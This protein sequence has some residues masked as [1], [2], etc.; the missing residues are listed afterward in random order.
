MFKRRG[1][2]EMSTWQ[3]RLKSGPPLEISSNSV[4]QQQPHI[5]SSTR[6]DS[7]VSR[8]RRVEESCAVAE[9]FRDRAGGESQMR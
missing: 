3:S 6:L 5:P 2:A 4:Q 9:K 8:N 1:L 7:Y